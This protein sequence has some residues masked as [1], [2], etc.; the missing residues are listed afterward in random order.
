GVAPGRLLGIEHP[1]SQARESRF[2]VE[3]RRQ[4][5]VVEEQLARLAA[6]ELLDQQFR[7]VAA[8]DRLPGDAPRRVSRRPGTQVRKILLV[9]PAAGLA[10]AVAGGGGQGNARILR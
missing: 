10:A 2:D 9:A 6:V 3:R 5:V 1:A 8:R 4:G 7:A